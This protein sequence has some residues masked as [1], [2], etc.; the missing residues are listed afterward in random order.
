[1]MAVSLLI[2][3]VF[4]VAILWFVYALFIKKEMRCRS[5]EFKDWIEYLYKEGGNLSTLVF[6]IKKNKNF[7][8]YK[9]YEE[10]DG[11]HIEIIFPKVK[12]SIPYIEKIVD[13]LNK[14][15]VSSTEIRANSS[16][17]LDLIVCDIGLNF[18]LGGEIAEAVFQDV[19][20]FKP[21]AVYKFGYSGLRK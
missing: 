18:E 5:D 1:M 20:G 21:G 16:D 10:K 9:K 12:W 14:K 8:Q 19:Y 4:L 7:V 2:S 15:G 6:W 11:V 17:E 13:T 3:A